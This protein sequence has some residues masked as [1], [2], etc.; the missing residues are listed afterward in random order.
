MLYS[1]HLKRSLFVPLAITGVALALTACGADEPDPFAEIP[2]FAVEAPV[3]QVL[4]QGQNPQEWEYTSDD[5]APTE[6]AKPQRVSLSRAIEQRPGAEDG[7]EPVVAREHERATVTFALSTHTSGGSGND[8]PR[9][10]DMVAQ[11]IEHSNLE[12]RN[13]LASNEGFQMRW[14]TDP[15]GAIS[16]VQ[17][18]PTVDS[19][20]EGRAI[21][22]RNL[23]ELMSWQVI[24][25][26]EPVGVGGTWKVEQRDVGSSDMLRTTTYTLESAQD[27][28]LKLKVDVQERPLKRSITIDNE[29]AGALDGTTLHVVSTTTYS[30]GTL[31]V[32]LHSPLPVGGS[33]LTATRLVYGS[34]DADT[35]VAQD[36]TSIVDYNV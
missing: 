10:V 35:R 13:R 8:A 29:V 7:S 19:D 23:L 36:S 25:P 12:M 6:D 9:Q 24:L 2:E 17:L 27:T 28:T 4:S 33:V 18:L 30:E 21:A 26:E 14:H 20:E 5:S 32:D 15:Q 22:E 3:V 11:S 16:A 1:A 34:D 31:T